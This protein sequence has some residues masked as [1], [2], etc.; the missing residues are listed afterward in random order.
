[1]PAFDII[2]CAA[3]ERD[4]LKIHRSCPYCGKMRYDRWLL[5]I[6][7]A[8]IGILFSV[9]VITNTASDR[10]I[11]GYMMLGT[12]MLMFFMNFA[13]VVLTLAELF[14]KP[15]YHESNLDK[16]LVSLDKESDLIIT[17]SVMALQFIGGEKSKQSILKMTKFNNKRART[18]IKSLV[19]VEAGD[20]LL[21]EIVKSTRDDVII[22]F[23]VTALIRMEQGN[24]IIDD[25]PSL[26]AERRAQVESVI[27]L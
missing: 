1:V 17:D 8:V 2:T 15:S 18:I 25:L 13:W 22:K 3:C 4:F 27:D 11:T 12:G 5:M 16:W 10:S 20:K 9:F 24:V 6:V 23:A 26:S 19:K 14:G 21:A 7:L